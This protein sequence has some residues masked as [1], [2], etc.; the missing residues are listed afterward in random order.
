[1]NNFN[2]IPLITELEINHFLSSAEQNA[3]KRYPKILHKKGDEFNR[4]FNFM[5]S[6]SYMHP[7]LHPGP[8]KNER[9]YIVSGKISVLYFNDLGECIKS[10]LLEKG[11]VELIEVPAYTWHT[12]VILTDHAIT[13]ETMM[14]VYEPNTWKKIAPWAPNEDYFESK[15]YLNQLKKMAK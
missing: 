8:E 12:Y 4:V 11:M 14:G 2:Q 1:M 7:H 10:T 9:I 5:M 15:N 6:E 3:R 13:Y